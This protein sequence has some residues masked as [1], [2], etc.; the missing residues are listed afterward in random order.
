MIVV[1]EIPYTVQAKIATAFHDE[2]GYMAP[3]ELL[4]WLRAKGSNIEARRSMLDQNQTVYIFPTEEEY[5]MFLLR[6][7]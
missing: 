6:W 4:G 2:N 7:S 5:T 1:T 3:E